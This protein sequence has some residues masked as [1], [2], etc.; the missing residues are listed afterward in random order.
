MGYRLLN[1]YIYKKKKTKNI[2]NTL[3]GHLEN[4]KRYEEIFLH[5]IS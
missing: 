4:D 2:E 3:A 1:I 5:S